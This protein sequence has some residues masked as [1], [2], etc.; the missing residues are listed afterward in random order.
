M[1]S[2]D[3]RRWTR[4][5]D[6]NRLPTVTEHYVLPP[7]QLQSQ[8]GSFICWLVS[9][10]RRDTSL[11]LRARPVLV[12]L[13]SVSLLFVEARVSAH[14]GMWRRPWR[15]VGPMSGDDI[16]RRCDL[17]GEPL[18]TPGGYGT[19]ALA[20]GLYCS[21]TCAALSTNRYVPPLTD[22]AEREGEA[23]DHDS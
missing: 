4:Q 5:S 11:N 6:P 13:R 19:G 23:D 2:L 18:P 22:I 3:L 17:C 10:P 12:Q 21:L 20:D 8:H 14:R 1:P 16:R 15:T 9:V 7:S